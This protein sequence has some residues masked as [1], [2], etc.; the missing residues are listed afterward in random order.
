MQITFISTVDITASPA[1]S[2]NPTPQEH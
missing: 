2:P 1:N